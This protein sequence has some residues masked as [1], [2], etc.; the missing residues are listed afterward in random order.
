MVVYWRKEGIAP[1]IL[2][3]GTTW[4]WVVSF[5]SKENIKMDL[6]EGGKLWDGLDSS[7]QRP[8][9]GCYERD[10]EPPWVHKIR[11]ISWPTESLFA[12]Q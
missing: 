6:R 12:S 3:I 8:V 7:G 9:A 1:H 4:R 5:T 10:N 11:V 2:D